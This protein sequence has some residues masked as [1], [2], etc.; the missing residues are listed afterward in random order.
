MADITNLLF[1]AVRVAILA[2][3]MVVPSLAAP[4]SAPRSRGDASMAG[5]R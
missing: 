4:D 2:P 3:P 5:H 1:V